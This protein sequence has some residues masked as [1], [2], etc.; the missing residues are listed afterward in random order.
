MSLCWEFCRCRTMNLRIGKQKIEKKRIYGMKPI[1]IQSGFLH[2]RTLLSYFNQF[3]F[4][5]WQIDDVTL[6]WRSGENFFSL[7]VKMNELSYWPIHYPLFCMWQIDNFSLEWK[8][9]KMKFV[10]MM[11]TRAVTWFTN[12]QFII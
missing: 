8:V 7:V 5:G 6:L 12:N 2:Q 3:L 11:S 9:R 10:N 1:H 4:C